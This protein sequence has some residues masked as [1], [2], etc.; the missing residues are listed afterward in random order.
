MNLDDVME[1]MDD[2][3]DK[4]LG[5][6][7]SGGKCIVDAE[8]MRDLINDM[9]INLPSEIKQAKLIVADRKI[10]L[11]DAK[12]EADAIIKRAEDKAKL[13]VA[14]EEVVKQAQARATEMMSQSQSRAKELRYA[15]NE[16][17]DNML[18][19]A[20]EVLVKDL[21]D[22]KRTKQVLKSSK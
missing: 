16:Y 19:Q 18:T 5:V 12:K 2:L 4:S 20:E 13:L 10:I 9:R 8:K 1:M 22:I 7:L 17:I 15:T 11:S 14:N 21:A 6:P 3:L